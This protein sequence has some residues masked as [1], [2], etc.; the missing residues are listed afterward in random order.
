M[1]AYMTLLALLPAVQ[2]RNNAT[3][4][5]LCTIAVA[6]VLMCGLRYRVLQSVLSSDRIVRHVT[7]NKHALELH[8]HCQ[9]SE[10][11]AEYR[12]MYATTI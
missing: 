5:L 1:G 12:P 8:Y 7:P 3:F 11:L 10:V 2:L 6:T 4:F 9:Y